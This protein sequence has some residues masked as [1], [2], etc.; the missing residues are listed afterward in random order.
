ML[1]MNRTDHKFRTMFHAAI[2]AMFLFVQFIAIAHGAAYGGDL[3][4][5]DAAPC[6]IQLLSAHGTGL[7]TEP[8][9]GTNVPFHAAPAEVE[10]ADTPEAIQPA[11]YELIRGPPPSAVE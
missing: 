6:K 8:P 4:D 5:H 2:A 9:S 10:T 3:H 7:A 11:R 1:G